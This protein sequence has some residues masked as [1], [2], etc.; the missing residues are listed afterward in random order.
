MCLTLSHKAIQKNQEATCLKTLYL[1]I[2]LGFLFLF[3]QIKEYN[4]CAFEIS[5]GA[6]ASS[7]YL[8]TGL[9]GS[10]VLVGGLL[11]V[12]SVWRLKNYKFEKKRHHGFYLACVY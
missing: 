2:I 6:F 12:H 10:H 11:L 9:H 8:L 5:D 7:F 1:T 4:D 3:L